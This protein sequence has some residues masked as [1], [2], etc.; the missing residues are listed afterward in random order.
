MPHFSP[1][2]LSLEVLPSA[3]LN[4]FLL[5]LSFWLQKDGEQLSTPYFLL[6]PL[7]QT[8]FSCLKLGVPVTIPALW[9]EMV[10]LGLQNERG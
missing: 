2:T 4:L 9:V 1:P 7:E 5:S 3:T 8:M 10:W 6:A